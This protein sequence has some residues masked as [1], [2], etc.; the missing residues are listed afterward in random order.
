[1]S[2]DRDRRLR[3]VDDEERV[4]EARHEE[5]RRTYH[6]KHTTV[7]YTGPLTRLAGVA[8]AVGAVVLLGY[9]LQTKGLGD[10]FGT[11]AVI[12]IV[13]SIGYWA[14][15]RPDKMR[16]R[17]GTFWRFADA[18]RESR[19]DISRYVYRRPFRVAVTIS[20]AY[21]VGIVLA[22]SAVVSLMGLIY[23]WRLAAA[24]GAAVG[25]LVIAP[26]FFIDIWRRAAQGSEQDD[27][28]EDD[29]Y[30]EDEEYDD[31][32]DERGDQDEGK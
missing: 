7:D 26:Q 25:A 29:Y 8:G 28:A 13:F 30:D 22:K 16:K 3:A 32:Y 4:A 5:P 31:E 18:A 10:E 9:Y 27:E 6:E 17:A 23:D 20:F 24:A 19:E 12:T 11:L 14:D 1:M 2:S 15:K 21:A